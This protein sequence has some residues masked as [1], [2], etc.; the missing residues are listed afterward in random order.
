M[1]ASR[2]AARSIQEGATQVR[3]EIL[4]MLKGPMLAPKRTV[5][6][7]ALSS[8]LVIRSVERQSRQID[9][10]EKPEAQFERREAERRD[11]E[12]KEAERREAERKEA[13]R[14]DAEARA[15]QRVR[16]RRAADPRRSSMKRDTCERRSVSPARAPRSATRTTAR[17][18]E[19]RAGPASAVEYRPTAGSRKKGRSTTTLRAGRA[20]SSSAAAAFDLRYAIRPAALTARAVLHPACDDSC[21]ALAAALAR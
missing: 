13:E 3:P 21:R 11:V 7:A 5:D 4:V 6:V 15:L 19:A 1:R 10:I 9:A 20:T 16:L 12:R 14:R 8:L 17:P 18:L 2:C